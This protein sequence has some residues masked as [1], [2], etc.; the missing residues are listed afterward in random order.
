MGRSLLMGAAV[1]SGHDPAVVA[2]WAG[3]AKERYDA[4]EK[5][6]SDFRNWGRQLTAAAGVVFGLEAA[7]M[8]QVLKLLEDSE[9]GLGV[10]VLLLLAAGAYQL[11]IMGRAIAAGYIGKELLSAESPAVLADHVAGKDESWLRQT[12]GAYYAKS[13]DNV[14]RAAEDVAKEVAMLA[15]HFKRSLWLLFGVVALTGA[16]SGFHSHAR[17]MMSDTPASASPAAPVPGAA[18]QNPSVPADAPSPAATPLLVTP[19]P[20]QTETRT[21]PSPG[22][23]LLSTPTP[24]Q[25]LTE[26]TGSP[27]K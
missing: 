15:R 11:A 17:K 23:K 13:S 7:L 2:L 4:G 9:L 18:P 6:L 24:G 20:G 22:E 19:T 12:I 25:R 5:R 3:Y 14:H 27:K 10:C 1:A 16:L 26:G 21:A 8:A